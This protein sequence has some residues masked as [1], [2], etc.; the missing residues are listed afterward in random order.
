VSKIAKLVVWLAVL[1]AIAAG[2]FVFWFAVI[3]DDDPLEAALPDVSSSTSGTTEP[4]VTTTTASAA[5]GVEGDWILQAGDG[6]EFFVGYNVE[7]TLRGIDATATGTTGNYEG[8]LTIDGEQ[9]T[10][11]AVTIDMTTLESDEGFRDDSIRDEGVETDTFPEATFS[12]TAPVALP[13]PPAT[14]EEVVVPVTGDL[15]LHGVTRSVTLDV[16]GRWNGDSIDVTG[17]IPIVFDDY[18]ITPP[19]RG[20][21]SVRDEGEIVFVLRFGR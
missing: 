12:I 14:G 5:Q 2:A 21:V 8:L 18:D 11:L 4:G 1:A 20:F 6:E 10:A 15:T 19:A 13:E 9:V 17:T 3:R 16:T 7:E